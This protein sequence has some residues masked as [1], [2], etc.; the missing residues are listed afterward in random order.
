[1]KKQLMEY[2]SGNEMAAIAIK[3]IGYDLM[4]YY[5]ICFTAIAAISFPDAYSIT[6]FSIR[7][8]LLPPFLLSDMIQK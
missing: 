2:A 8:H 4:G 3:Q 1:M 7:R 6:C 5:P